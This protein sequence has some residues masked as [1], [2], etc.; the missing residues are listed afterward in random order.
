[1]TTHTCLQAHHSTTAQQQRQHQLKH[2][3][4]HSVRIALSINFIQR[5]VRLLMYT[6]IST[7]CLKNN[8]IMGLPR[9]PWRSMARSFSPAMPAGA[10]S[11][12]IEDSRPRFTS[13]VVL[14]PP[15][16]SPRR[17][18][19]LWPPLSR[20]APACGR[21]VAGPRF[22]VAGSRL[23]PVS[24]KIPQPSPRND[25]FEYWPGTPQRASL[26]ALSLGAPTPRSPRRS[27]FGSLLEAYRV[28]FLSWHLRGLRPFILRHAL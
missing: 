22:H 26:R 4:Q 14:P 3:A 2:N 5:H 18:L 7:S 23:R 24:D 28:L 25:H 8:S 10:T 6:Q 17:R 20:F 1:M 13:F 12:Q 19:P 16:P 21:G 11:V 15:S 9:R 27:G